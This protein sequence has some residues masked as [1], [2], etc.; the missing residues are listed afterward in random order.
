LEADEEAASCEEQ[1][2]DK[3]YQWYSADKVIVLGA[4]FQGEPHFIV[5]VIKGSKVFVEVRLAQNNEGLFLF[6]FLFWY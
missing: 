6:I 4:S 3:A 1:E 2:T 5:S